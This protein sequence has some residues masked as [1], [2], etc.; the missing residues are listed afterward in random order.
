EAGVHLEGIDL[1]LRAGELALIEA[2]RGLADLLVPAASCGMLRPQS[3]RVLYEGVD[4]SERSAANAVST[5]HGIG[6]V[7]EGTEWLSNLNVDEN[8]LL[9]A[10]HHTDRAEAD[11]IAEAHAIAARFGI[12]QLTSL[13][14]N[15][16]TPEELRVYA[17]VRAFLDTPKLVVLARPLRG[18]VRAYSGALMDLV[19]E[20]CQSGTAVLW[21]SSEQ[22]ILG[23]DQL[24]PDCRHV[25]EPPHLRETQGARS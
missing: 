9:S 1:R 20:S 19:R 12:Q 22:N 21:I 24:D 10:C 25:I 4:W 18:V 23:S 5:R 7:F 6:Q 16:V 14:P 17:I 3:G 13:R 11:L 2:R 15:L 8:I